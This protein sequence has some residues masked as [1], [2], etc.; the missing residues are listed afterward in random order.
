MNN[1]EIA[2]LRKKEKI[3]G[4]IQENRFMIVCAYKECPDKENCGLAHSWE[5][6]N[7]RG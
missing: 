5:N 2:K 3:R 1:R 6:K 4:K 7:E